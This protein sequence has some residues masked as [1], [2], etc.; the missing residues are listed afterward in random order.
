M[1][2]PWCRA[3]MVK[4]QLDLVKGW[5]QGVGWKIPYRSDW[6]FT[7][8]MSSPALGD[9][10]QELRQH[11][12]CTFMGYSCHYCTA[13]LLS[14]SKGPVGHWYHQPHSHLQIAKRRLLLTFKPEVL[15]QL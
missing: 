1:C 4:G 8:G 2:L 11:S 10:S 7:E 3:G 14:G 9:H 15:I 13:D 6:N 12:Y 5:T